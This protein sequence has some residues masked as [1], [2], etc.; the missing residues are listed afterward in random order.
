M[1][2]KNL[3]I[4][5]II[6]AVIIVGIVFALTRG[7]NK[8]NKSKQNG[9]GGETS[10][11]SKPR[12]IRDN[13]IYYVTING[14]KFKAGDKISSI[15]KVDLKQRDKD[16]EDEIPKNRYLMSQSVINSNGK[17]ICKFV[18]LN[19]TDAKITAKDA[20]IGGFEI[21]DYNY[22]K[23]DKEVLDYNIEVVGG[24]KLGSSYEDIK[25]VLGEEDFKHEQE[26]NEKLKMPAYTTYEY[27]SGYKGYTFIVDNNGK[28]S[29]IKWNDYDFD[30]K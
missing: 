4:I 19:S 20:V 25:K 18:P 5:V 22:D 30:E 16:M 6:V 14:T 26:T 23:I 21:G 8:N 13:D 2:K 11:N 29:Q 15:S 17:K 12:S 3:I 1:K 7:D 10:Q 28:V 9:N 24:I 27:S